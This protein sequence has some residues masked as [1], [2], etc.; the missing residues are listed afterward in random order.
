MSNQ[1][2]GG[3]QQDFGLILLII[4]VVAGGYVLWEFMRESTIT[5]LVYTTFAKA[6]VVLEARALVGQGLDYLG[7][8]LGFTYALGDIRAYPPRACWPPGVDEPTR[9]MIVRPLNN[10]ITQFNRGFFSGDFDPNNPCHVAFVYQTGEIAGRSVSM[11]FA[12]PLLL[13]IG[14]YIVMF[15]K[16]SKFRRRLGLDTLIGFQ[17][18]QWKAITPVV[19]L[20]PLKD[21]KGYWQESISPREW[22]ESNGIL[23]IDGI[24]DREGVRTG[25]SKQLRNPWRGINGMAL[26]R[27][28]LIAVFALQAKRKS[29]DCRDVLYALATGWAD[30]QSIT[31]LMSKDKKLLGRINKILNDKGM[32]G[33]LLNV[34]MKHAYEES[35]MAAMLTYA[36][37]QGGVLPS[38]EFLWLKPED[39]PLWYILNNVGR[40][41]FHVEC[42][43]AV[44]HWKA[45]VT[46]G[47]PLPEPDVDEAVFGLEEF[48]QREIE[49]AGG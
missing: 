35:A 38:A 14:V 32:I 29:S 13:L 1:Q 22:V 28:A 47:R 37:Q 16:G 46:A 24:P 7:D 6:W 12:S 5:G 26:H 21:E 3:S 34:A 10:F 11:Y 33:P 27:R 45:E 40:P 23:M 43:G 36:R 4:C 41:T 15:S 25:L 18:Q 20:N 19:K 49:L 39:R 2:G 42:A 8:Q 30:H 44:A 31:K 48:F 9:D 17:A